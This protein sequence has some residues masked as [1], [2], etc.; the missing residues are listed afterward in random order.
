MPVKYK[1]ETAQL[2]TTNN[3]PHTGIASKKNCE[4]RKHELTR[5]QCSSSMI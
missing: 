5:Y 3:K 1:K 2:D 4:G